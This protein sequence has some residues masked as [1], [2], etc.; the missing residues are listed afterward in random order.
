MFGTRKHGGRTYGVAAL[1]A[2]ALALGACGGAS[3]APAPASFFGVVPQTGLT[4]DDFE[5]MGDGKVGTVR[6][7]INWSVIDAS[8]TAGDE[9]WS[10]ID[11]IVLEAARNGIAVEPFIF[12]TPIWVAKGLDHFKCK[13]SKCAGYA[14]KSKQALDAFETFVGQAVDRY[15][16]DGE[17]WALH[18]DVPKDPI[19]VWQILNEQNSKSFYRRSRT[20]RATRRCWPPPTRRSTPVI[21][22]PTW[23]SAG[24]RSSPGRRRRS[25]GRST[26]P[27][28]TR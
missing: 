27:S 10:S 16:P 11:P 25:R 23:C 4:S 24:W 3:A 1:A 22:G 2:A 15:G 28:S 18:Q 9:D 14:P 7:I 20:R 26:S 8:A 6:T 19:D 21:R 5:R 17:F 13:S 12:G